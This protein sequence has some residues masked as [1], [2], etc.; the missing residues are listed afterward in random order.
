MAQSAAISGVKFKYQVSLDGGSNYSDVTE[1]N[2]VS[3]N[4]EPITD[5]ATNKGTSVAGD[6]TVWE[7][8]VVVAMRWSG[9]VNVNRLDETVQNGIRAA[10][11]TG[12]RLWIKAMPEVGSGKE[13][14]TGLAIFRLQNNGPN[15]NL[16][17]GVYD[18]TGSGP[19]TRSTQ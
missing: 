9:Q 3:L 8:P 4:I 16:Q 14:Y 2:D 12:T 5:D 11:M 1:Q 6:G 17:R 19:L 18:L 15:T 10:V 7:E 13:V